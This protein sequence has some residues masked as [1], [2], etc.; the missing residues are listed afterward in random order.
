MSSPNKARSIMVSPLTAPTVKSAPMRG[1]RNQY[2]SSYT[3]LTS[4][5]RAGAALLHPPAYVWSIPTSN[6]TNN[7]KTHTKRPINLRRSARSDHICACCICLR[8]FLCCCSCV[9]FVEGD[10]TAHK[11]TPSLPRNVAVV[12]VVVTYII[13]HPRVVLF[14]CYT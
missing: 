6:G 14:L 13:R 2:L 8:Y 5:R 12:L 7:K 4:R 9:C 1:G 11:Q 10:R 3:M